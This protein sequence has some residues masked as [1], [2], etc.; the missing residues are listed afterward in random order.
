MV[1]ALVMRIFV[2]IVGGGEG[3]WDGGGSGGWLDKTFSANMEVV[4]L[5]AML[6]RPKLKS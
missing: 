1:I 4:L 6:G 2:G 3:H 5:C